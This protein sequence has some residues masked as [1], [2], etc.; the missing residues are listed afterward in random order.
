MAAQQ[1]DWQLLPDARHLADVSAV[2]YALGP[3]AFVGPPFLTAY[4]PH[5][6]VALLPA[7]TT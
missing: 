2:K 7:H 6:C 5:V 4:A 1:T 3:H